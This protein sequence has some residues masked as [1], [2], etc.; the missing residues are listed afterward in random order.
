MIMVNEIIDI[1]GGAAVFDKAILSTNDLIEQIEIGLP[2]ETLNNVVTKIATNEFGKTRLKQDLIPQASL[3]RRKDNLSITQSEKIERLARVIA[4]ANYVWPDDEDAVK[5]FMH[6]PHPIFNGKTP[7][8]MIQTE[9][10]ARQVEELLWKIF[11]GI[12]V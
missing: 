1:M 2:K 6:N 3:N 11:Y 9:L 7:F 12:A 4:T 5:I 10:G 8:N